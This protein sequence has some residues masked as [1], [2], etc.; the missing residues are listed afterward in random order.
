MQKFDSDTDL[1]KQWEKC[2]CSFKP[3]CLPHKKHLDAPKRPAYLLPT[4]LSFISYHN[5]WPPSSMCLPIPMAPSKKSS[6]NTMLPHPQV[7]VFGAVDEWGDKFLKICPAYGML[8]TP[9]HD[10]LKIPKV[11]SFESVTSNQVIMVYKRYRWQCGG[12]SCG[13][14]QRKK[15]WQPKLAT[16]VDNLYLPTKIWFK[17][18]S[19]MIVITIFILEDNLL[20]A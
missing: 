1:K 19:N 9:P 8:S 17:C 2:I 14:W 6:P 7:R 5:D 11:C 15:N 16:Q 13:E 12:G 3:S 20:P 4:L 10:I 18:L